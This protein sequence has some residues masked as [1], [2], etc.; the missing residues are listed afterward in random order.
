[1]D[2]NEVPEK[3]IPVFGKGIVEYID[4]RVFQE[5]K[6]MK[7]TSGVR[8]QIFENGEEE[9]CTQYYTCAGRFKDGR[10]TIQASCGASCLLIWSN[11]SPKILKKILVKHGVKRPCVLTDYYYL[12]FFQKRDA[13]YIFPYIKECCDEISRE[14][15][16]LFKETINYEEDV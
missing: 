5:E 3:I 1:M 13:K 8:I 9:I 14:K 10:K 4:G 12:K 15:I 16:E 2:S 6:P 7:K 11:K